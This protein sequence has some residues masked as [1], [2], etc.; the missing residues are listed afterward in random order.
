[1]GETIK[2]LFHWLNDKKIGA[3]VM[4]DIKLKQQHESN[5]RFNRQTHTFTKTK[6]TNAIVRNALRTGVHF[7][8]VNP[9]YTSV[10]GRF[11]YSQKYGISVHEAASFVIARRGLGYDEKVPKKVVRVLRSVVKPHLIGK[12]GSME[13]S[14][15][16]STQGKKQ[17]QYL[18]ML[19]KNIDTFK[20]LHSW[21]TWNVVHKTLRFDQ[22]K[23]KM[24]EV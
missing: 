12:L 17:R 2:A 9:A 13:E 1:M 4:E 8:K 20:E 24:K 21:K 22:C 15:K 14:V 6:L 19:L 3:I 16:H 7:K 10:I 5:K 18:G 11:K 23:F